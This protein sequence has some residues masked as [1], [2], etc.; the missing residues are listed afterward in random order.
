MRVTQGSPKR[1]QQERQPRRVEVHGG[2]R[3]PHQ[4]N[5]SEACG[6]EV[7][8]P[9]HRE[10]FRDGRW[11]AAAGSMPREAVFPGPL[12]AIRT[13]ASRARRRAARRAVGRHEPAEATA[14][15]R[16]I[17]SPGGP[18][19]RH[20]WRTC[21]SLVLRR[22]AGSGSSLCLE[23]RGT[24]C[25]PRG[26]TAA[27][28]GARH[29]ARLQLRARCRRLGGGSGRLSAGK[30]RSPERRP[31]QAA[32][33]AREDFGLGTSLAPNVLVALAS[34]SVQP[35]E[36]HSTEIPA[37]CASPLSESSHAFA[38]ASEA[39]TRSRPRCSL[40]CRAQVG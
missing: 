10:G 7:R 15:L 31:L 4:P 40:R 5:L 36:S 14:G 9:R 37:G 18:A 24:D 32:R 33:W 13:G 20:S 1:G 30:A 27:C 16:G 39:M 19:R 11:P 8:D 17:L 3:E 35:A 23:A 6:H 38:C 2:A 28:W 29:H 25:A 21:D 26:P 34:E 12:R 22:A